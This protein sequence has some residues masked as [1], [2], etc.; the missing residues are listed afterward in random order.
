MLCVQ[1]DYG[2]AFGRV[3]DVNGRIVTDP[4]HFV[5]TGTERNCVNPTACENRTIFKKI[6]LARLSI[7]L[8]TQFEKKSK[9][10]NNQL[11]N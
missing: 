3:S 2:V 11:C 5:A 9:Y 6:F 4:T 8:V 7:I 1:S 10:L